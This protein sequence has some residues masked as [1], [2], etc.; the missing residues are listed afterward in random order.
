MGTECDHTQDLSRN[1]FCQIC[2][3]VKEPGSL[4]RVR[5]QGFHGAASL[6]PKIERF[7]ETG[8]PEGL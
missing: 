6:N 5:L 1:I 8:D 2:G 4:K 3:K 7:W